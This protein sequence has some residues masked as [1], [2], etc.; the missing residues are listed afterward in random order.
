MAKIARIA[1]TKDLEMLAIALLARAI[2]SSERGLPPILGNISFNCSSL[3]GS[4]NPDLAAKNN[5]KINNLKYSGMPEN[6][7]FYR[8]KI[9]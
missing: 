1:G 2:I 6:K 8:Q 4:Y 7:G 3:W 5:K 9:F